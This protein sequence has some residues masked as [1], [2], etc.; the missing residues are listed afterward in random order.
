M[1]KATLIV[2]DKERVQSLE[3]LK[4]LGLLHIEEVQTESEKLEQL[5]QDYETL[6]R[7]LTIIPAEKVETKHGLPEH[8]A[9]NTA[10]ETAEYVLKR[11]E[12]LRKHKEQRDKI[13]RELERLQVWGDFNP[14]DIKELVEENIHI[15][16][17]QAS[18]DALKQPVENGIV[19]PVKTTKTTVYVAV[20]SY[21]EAPRLPDR[22]EA[23]P[24]PEKSTKQ[25]KTDLELI[26]SVITNNQDEIV[27][28][29]PLRDELI[30]AENTLAEEIEF[31][32]VRAGMGS[33]EQIAFLTGYIP[34]KKADVLKKAAQKNS[35]GLIITE[36]SPDDAVPTLVEHRGI[37]KLTKPVFEL[38]GIVPGYQE[39]DI[40]LIFLIALLVFVGMIVGDAGYG[41]ILVAGTAFAQAKL[42]SVPKVTF[43]LLYFMWAMVII[44]GSITGTW[45]GSEFLAQE[46]FLSMFVIPEIA[47]FPEMGVDSSK[48]IMVICFILGLI[49]LSLACIERFFRELPS[50]KAFAQ[51]G[52]LLVL[53]GAMYFVMDMVIGTTVLFGIDL[54]NLLILIPIGLGMIV[55]FSEQKGN[56]FKGVLHGLNP[57]NIFMY[58]MDGINSFANI[59][60]YVRLF[61]VGLATVAVAESFNQLALSIPIPVVPVVVLFLGHSL[62]II[63]AV[64]A[65][66]VHGLRLN[67][68]E[69][70]RQMGLEWSGFEYNPFRVKEFSK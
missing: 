11:N 49:Q 29:Y 45:F 51:I 70:S 39:V 50:L 18:K 16:L 58:L 53:F 31:E 43:H 65:I 37:T 56:F 55:L 60:S 32:R 41:L 2:F 7:A 5:I 44:W 6:Q 33:E 48:N 8:L 52:W 63:M 46:T 47:S 15:A 59:I 28:L 34:E 27:S 13:E 9:D 57:I 62:N 69:Y 4:Q 12:E 40:S 14:R 42:K 68:L 61:A 25:L 67:M 54:S 21:K 24:L 10:L 26:N 20:I 38:L 30:E 19:I 66:A 22:Y 36:P 23:V 64:L 17:C 1:K 3:K 35:W